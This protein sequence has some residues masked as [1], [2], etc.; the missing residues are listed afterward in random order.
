M[1]RLRTFL[2]WLFGFFSGLGLVLVLLVPLTVVQ[3]SNFQ[4]SNTILENIDSGA[5]LTAAWFLEHGENFNVTIYSDSERIDYRLYGPSQLIHDDLVLEPVYRDSLK[6]AEPGSYLI[7]LKNLDSVQR[8]VMLSSEPVATDSEINNPAG[9]VTAAQKEKVTD[10]TVT[11]IVGV[12]SAGVAAV[13]SIYVT[14]LQ[15]N[16][17]RDSKGHLGS[18]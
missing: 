18:G 4:V 15:I 9:S 12:I 14:R 3:Q 1:G 16:A 11:I 7:R 8:S 10:W 13:A 17:G 6:A 5:T 2:I